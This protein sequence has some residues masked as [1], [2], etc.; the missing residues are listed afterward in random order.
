MDG[1][2]SEYDYLNFSKNNTVVNNITLG[3]GIKF[4]D[5]IDKINPKGWKQKRNI[6]ITTQALYNLKKTTLKR[7]IELSIISGITI[8][9]ISNE[10]VVHCGDI[11][12]DY[13]YTSA[14][15]KTIIELLA[16]FW[17]QIRDEELPL[18]EVNSKSLSAYVTSKKEKEKQKTT[19]MPTSG[20]I[21][22]G[23]FLIRYSDQKGKK[24]VKGKIS[25][26]KNIPVNLSDFKMLKTIGR[27]SVGKILLVEYKDHHKYAMKSIRKDQ[28]VSEGITDNI[29]IEKNILL[30]GQCPFILPLIFFFQTNLRLY[31]V[32]PFIG[33]GDLFHRLKKE[34]F[35]KE[36]EVKFYA[37]QVG[38]ALEY[39]H[40]MGICYRD[41]KPENILIDEDGYIKL[42]DFGACCK[43]SGKKTEKS[44]GGS[45]EYAAPEVI[46]QEGHTFLADWWSL[47]I[48]IYELLYGNTPFFNMEEERM[49][50]LIK[51]GSISFPKII[52]I[53]GEPKERTYK[54][55]EDAKNL[56]TKLLAKEPNERLGKGGFAE[57]KKHPFFNGINFN[58]LQVKKIK[59]I[60][61]PKVDDIN[62][63]FEE[64]YLEMDLAESPT[65][66][67]IKEPKFSNMFNNFDN[68][69]FEDLGGG[70][71]DDDEDDD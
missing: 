52:C 13:H 67:W 45:A 37:A 19:K 48:L 8:S 42:C 2:Q 5:K 59:P 43:I 69:A 44:F 28:L 1:K 36:E 21:K 15:R 32:T 29:L 6:I 58:D 7:K 9:K 4:S 20:K 60:Y 49:F 68:D 30:D 57:I 61:K 3:E 55:S 51:A 63:N 40:N 56:I 46:T 18:F 34:C 22:L 54:I 66:D 71:A 10:F 31:F 65:S 47:G 33:G 25:T 50:D 53:E 12:Y 26:F 62:E 35:L 11:D 39:L 17:E 24:D 16:K 23:D 70:D 14:K 64:E 38:I 41:L 27:G